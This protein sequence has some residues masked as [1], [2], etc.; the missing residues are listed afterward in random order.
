MIT[1]MQA[2]EVMFWIVIITAMQAHEVMF[3]IVM[4]HGHANAAS[5]MTIEQAH[6][7]RTVKNDSNNNMLCNSSSKNA[8][9][10]T[11]EAG[12]PLTKSGVQTTTGQK[13]AW[14]AKAE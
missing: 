9:V 2:H 12:T 1:A 4:I 8:L 13:H 6:S 5:K 11:K 14:P 3:W 7:M 10:V